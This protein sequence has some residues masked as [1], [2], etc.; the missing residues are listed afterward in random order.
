MP[1]RKVPMPVNTGRK[2]AY[3]ARNHIALLHSAQEVLAKIGPD[4]TIDQ[5]AEHADVSV[6]TIYKHFE[7][8]EELFESASIDAMRTWEI[9]ADDI[10][11]DVKDPLKE[12]VFPMRL[13]LRIK[14]THPIYA[15]MIGNNLAELPS[16]V[17]GIAS[18]LALHIKELVKAKILEMD[19]I[20]IR[21][22]SVSACLLAAMGNQLQSPRAKESEADAAVEIAIGILGIS[23]AKAKKLAHEKLPSI[24]RS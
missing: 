9:W 14:H 16:Y 22:Q 12:L 8:K 4:A 3:F 17:P 11:A 1:T 19:N 6:S 21:I 13:L 2:A 18:G 23:P 15:R 24:K 10:L 5:I 20:E 7:T